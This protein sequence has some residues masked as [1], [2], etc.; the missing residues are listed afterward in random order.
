[1]TKR[2]KDRIEELVQLRVLTHPV[3]VEVLDLYKKYIDKDARFCLSCDGSVRIMM[4]IFKKWWSDKTTH[5]TFIKP[6]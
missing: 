1:M 2:E 6:I 5:Y 3:K 4:K